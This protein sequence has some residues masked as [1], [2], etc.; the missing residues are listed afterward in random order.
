MNIKKQQLVK[1]LARS[2]S[3]SHRFNRLPMEIK[4]RGMTPPNPWAQQHLGPL[5]AGKCHLSGA[6]QVG[7]APK[8]GNSKLSLLAHQILLSMGKVQAPAIVYLS[9]DCVPDTKK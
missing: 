4:L 8:A 9:Q 3:Q 6:I 1:I 5:V 7:I 2:S